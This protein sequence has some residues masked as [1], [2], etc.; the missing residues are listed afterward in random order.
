MDL[1]EF[2]TI[3]TAT[4]TLKRAN[5]QAK[6]APAC[7]AGRGALRITDTPVSSQYW[8]PSRRNRRRS[9]T[10]ST[11]TR[12]SMTMPVAAAEPYRG[13]PLKASA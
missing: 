9:S 7:L 5:S 1:S 6:A 12:A 8:T 13:T 3:Q 4:A 11:A 2:S 10:T